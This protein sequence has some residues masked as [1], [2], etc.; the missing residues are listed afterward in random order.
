MSDTIQGYPAEDVEEGERVA[1]SE[2][3]GTTYL[4]TRWVDKGDGKMIALKKT[5]ISRE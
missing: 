3:T 5:E 1:H 2:L 4:V